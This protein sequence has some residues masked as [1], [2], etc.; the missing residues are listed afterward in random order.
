HRPSE[1]RTVLRRIFSRLGTAPLQLI[2][3]VIVLLVRKTSGQN[4]LANPFLTGRTRPPSEVKRH[5]VVVANARSTE[6]L[7][8]PVLRFRGVAAAPSTAAGGKPRR[9]H[10]TY[11]GAASPRIPRMARHTS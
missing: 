3:H 10:A 6:E 8:P 11:A 4:I 9:P 2:A 7:A 5:G 1:D